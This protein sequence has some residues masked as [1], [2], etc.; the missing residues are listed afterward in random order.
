MSLFQA[1]AVHLRQRLAEPLPGPAAQYRMAP[2]ERLPKEEYLSRSTDYRESAVMVL[3]FPAEDEPT[4]VLTERHEYKGVHSGQVS[5]P[6][7]RVEEQDAD[8]R[9]TALREMQ[10]EIGVASHEVEVIGHLTDLYIPPSRFMVYPY[11]GVLPREPVF[12]PDPVEVKTI[13]EVPLR[14]LLQ[15]HV[16][17][18]TRM[19]LFN[20][21][22]VDT[23]YFDVQGR[24][25]WGATA[26][27]ISELLAVVEK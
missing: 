13:L 14:Y 11:V 12:Y 19:K 3:L 25:V 18:H 15:P 17:K 24:V 7:G 6:G 2:A 9:H 10:E 5:F 27:I 16:R 26:M 8:T 20:N 21:L 23:P 22:I 4:L 1:T